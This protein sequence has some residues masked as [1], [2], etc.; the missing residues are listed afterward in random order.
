MRYGFLALAAAC[1]GAETTDG[2]GSP[3]ADTATPPSETTTPPETT[4]PPPP[5]SETEVLVAH[6]GGW[7][8]TTSTGWTV[9]VLDQIVTVTT[10]DGTGKVEWW[11]F[12]SA[13][14]TPPVDPFHENLNG[15]HIKDTLGGVRSLLLPDGAKITA[16]SVSGVPGIQPVSLY[17]Q[18]RAY[19]VDALANT[20]TSETLEAAAAAEEEEA[21]ADGETAAVYLPGKGVLEYWNVYQ[22]DED[23][24][25]TP[26]D[27]VPAKQQLGETGGTANPNQV[28][29]FYDDPRLIHT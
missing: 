2:P 16:R 21:E 7:L 4:D 27:A 25:G 17:D 23:L 3:T 26:L 29:D 20:L 9:F 15:K 5:P 8:W 6:K 28:N 10:P 14:Q 1:G 18:G 13:G 19:H 24:D 11:G 12:T 22:Q